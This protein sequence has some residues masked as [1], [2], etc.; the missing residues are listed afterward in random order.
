MRVRKVLHARC[1][2][3]DIAYVEAGSG[4]PVVLLHGAGLSHR[5]W[6]R[7]VETLSDTYRV[8]ALDLRGHGDTRSSAAV[9]PVYEA[10]I[11]ASDL[12]AFLDVLGLDRVHLVG[13]SLGGMIA[14][15]FATSY[16]N[17]LVSLV[18]VGTPVDTVP[19]VFRRAAMALGT[20]YLFARMAREGMEWVAAKGARR[21]TRVPATREYIRDDAARMDPE[22]FK[23]VWRGVG[24]YRLRDRLPAIAVPTLVVVGDRDINRRQAR[25]ASR[26]IPGARLVVLP[27]IGHITN[28]DAPDEFL[29]V[30]GQ[31]LGEHGPR[32]SD[33]SVS[34]P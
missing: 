19:D 32:S 26:L 25:L 4:V 28:R 29:A 18:T 34:R 17:R 5:L 23:R 15:E 12:L 33:I 24:R 3:L 6:E 27:G 1:G 7:E 21:M 31:W 8:I 2:D 13:L 22:E 10:A 30:L 11:Y 16:S 9:G 20:R 14:Q